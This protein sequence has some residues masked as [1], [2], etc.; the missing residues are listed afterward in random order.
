MKKSRG[1]TTTK[2]LRAQR[3]AKAVELLNDGVPTATMLEEL[4]IS[5]A[6]FWRYLQEIE[7]HY[8]SGSTED[9]KQFKKAQYQAL[10]QI[11]DATAKGTI[12]PDVSNAL[13]R[14]RSE[15]AKLLGLNAESRSVVAHVTATVTQGSHKVLP[16]LSG[17]TELQLDQVMRFAESLPRT[18]LPKAAGPPPRMLEGETV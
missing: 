13:T 6:T 10:L 11:E 18:P 2:A 9:I 5:R 8:V 17:L 3:Q 4:Q 12:P 1:N 15:V 7:A 16:S 14:I